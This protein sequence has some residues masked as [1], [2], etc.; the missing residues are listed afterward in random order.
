MS[1]GQFNQTTN[2]QTCHILDK[3]KQ[4]TSGRTIAPHSRS[5]IAAELKMSKKVKH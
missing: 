3:D 4:S 1:D 5:D 2:Q